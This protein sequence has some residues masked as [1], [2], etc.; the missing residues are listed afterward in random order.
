MLPS[1]FVEAC[2]TAKYSIGIGVCY[3]QLAFG[4]EDFPDDGGVAF[5]ND[6]YKYANYYFQAMLHYLDDG[7]KDVWTVRNRDAVLS[8]TAD[9]LVRVAATSH[10]YVRARQMHL[11]N[12]DPRNRHLRITLDWLANAYQVPNGVP[13][14]W[15]KIVTTIRDHDAYW[16]SA[17]RL[18]YTDIAG[19]LERSIDDDANA[20]AWGGVAFAAEILCFGINDDEWTPA[21]NADFAVFMEEANRRLRQT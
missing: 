9:H 18:F 12:V 3:A 10:F 8:L 2:N 14:C 5:R 4:G 11:A 21:C 7:S 13:M 15:F 17:L 6:V 16:K 20:R 1:E 19:A